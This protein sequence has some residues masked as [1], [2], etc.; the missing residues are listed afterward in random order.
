MDF[1][2]MWDSLPKVLAGA[3]MT[4]QLT[5][6]ALG[7]GFVLATVIALAS[8]SGRRWLSLPADGYVYVFRST[9]LLVQIF[10]IYYGLGQFQAV[11]ASFLWPFL[12][13]PFACAVLALMLNTGAYTAEIIKGGIRSVPWG[14][15]EAA[16]ACGMSGLLLFRRILFPVAFRQA[17][18]AYGNEIILM[19]KASSLASTITLLEITGI[20]RVIIAETFRPIELFI[21]SGGIYLVINAV[22][23]RA[24]R[25]LELYLSP[26]LKDSLDSEQRRQQTLGVRVG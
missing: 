5:F 8:L 14:Q 19:I 25:A 12:R 18:P 22:L 11:R 23:S 26:Q 4:F 20:A 17:L 24:V 9:P 21:V 16:R 15:V 7:L 1:A 2:L 6:L 13:E 10:L 3:G